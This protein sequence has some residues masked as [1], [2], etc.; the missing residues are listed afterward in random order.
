MHNSSTNSEQV[1]RLVN[2]KNLL[3]KQSIIYAKDF[4]KT[5]NDLKVANRELKDSYLDTVLRLSLAAECR[6]K[7]TGDH[8]AR[9]S[10]YSFFIAKEIG[11]PEKTTQNILFAAPMHDVGKIG[12]PDAI[13]L[14]KGKLNTEEY[15]IIKTHCAIGARILSD[16]QSEILQIAESIALTHHERWNGKGYPQGISREEIP[17]EGRIIALADVF[18][19]LISQRPYK[20]PFSFETAC[21]II[22]ENRGKHFEPALVDLFFENYKEIK[23]MAND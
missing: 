15:E 7:Y 1:E 14:K 19:A 17:I 3:I 12:I 2:D 13:L 16:S 4:K 5:I 18:D 6:D 9:I 8:I 11:L 23:E 22:R 21:T 10:K 20:E